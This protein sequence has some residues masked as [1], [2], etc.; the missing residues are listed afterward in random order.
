MSCFWR[1]VSLRHLQS[2]ANNG[3]EQLNLLGP[4]RGGRR[5]SHTVKDGPSRA[6]DRAAMQ[7]Y[8]P[9]NNAPIF[10]TNFSDPA[11]L[12]ADWNPVS[13]DNEWGDFPSCRRPSNVQPSRVG[14]RLK[15][16]IA[17]DCPHK[18]STD[19]IDRKAKYSYGFF[20]ATM[21]IADIKGMNN[22]FWMTTEDHPETG[23]HF[24]IDVSEVQYPNYDH[25]GLQHSLGLS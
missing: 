25:I 24:E 13:D 8:R 5:I 18:W 16:L 10:S 20:E 4:S 22:A 3:A 15:T 14:L 2:P 21:K 19:Y 9:G 17:T 11:E 1:N 7:S 23:D 6:A 12:R